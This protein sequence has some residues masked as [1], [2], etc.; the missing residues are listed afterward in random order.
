MRTTQKREILAYTF[1]PPRADATCRELLALLIPSN[2]GM[3][4]ESMQES[5]LRKSS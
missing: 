2:I 5:F 3:L 1:G 4:G